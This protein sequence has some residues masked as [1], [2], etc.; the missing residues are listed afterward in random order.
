MQDF[1][2]NYN[3]NCDTKC[4]YW[5][6]PTGPTG[7]TGPAGIQGPMGPVGIAG[8]MGPVGPTGSSGTS[9]STGPTGATG[10]A[11]LI[12]PTGATGPSGSTYSL[13]DSTFC[14]CNAQLA[15]LIRQ[16]IDI[17]AGTTVRVYTATW[18]TVEGIPTSLYQSPDASGPELFI[19]TDNTGAS[20]AVSLNSIVAIYPGAGSTYNP[21]ITYL[22]PKLPLSPGCDTDLMYAIHD[23]LPVSAN[24]VNVYTPV[25][26]DM[27]NKV[28]YKNEYGILVL[29]TNVSG[30]E[31]YFVPSLKITFIEK[32]LAPP[33]LQ[34]ANKIITN[35]L[36]SVINTK[37]F[38]KDN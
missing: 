30:A 4:P 34:L 13:A 10:P 8:P 35:K 11:G 9:G 21:S 6:G 19:L 2:N 37:D 26:L 22:E 16:I 32:N 24:L 23:Y 33:A 5:R 18:F 28:V 27:T 38:N 14:F 7:A 20:A 31:P 36:V 3:F 15:N 12:G 17:Y 25:L 29:C 1:E